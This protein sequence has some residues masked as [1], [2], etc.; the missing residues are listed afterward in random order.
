MTSI[1]TMMMQ[2]TV[3]NGNTATQSKHSGAKSDT[4]KGMIASQMTH[5]TASGTSNVSIDQLMT[6]LEDFKR[7]FNAEN[8][9]DLTLEEIVDHLQNELE[10]LGF[11]NFQSLLK[12]VDRTLPITVPSKSNMSGSGF[13]LQVQGGTNASAGKTDSAAQQSKI[14]HLVDLLKSSGTAESTLHEFVKF[15]SKTDTGKYLPQ[16][17]NLKHL[18]NQVQNQL[19]QT[20]SGDKRT[21]LSNQLGTLQN[22]HHALIHTYQSASQKANEQTNGNKPIKGL[23]IEAPQILGLSSSPNLMSKVEQYVLHAPQEQ[24]SPAR[25]LN[26]MAKMMNRG[27]LMSLPNG[28]TQLS[29]KLFPENL[30]ALDIQIVQRNGEIAAK[31]IASTAQAKELIE[32]NLNQLRHVLQG[33]NITVNQIEVSNHVPDWMNDEREK[34]NSENPFGRE[35]KNENEDEENGPQT[36]QQWMEEL[37]VEGEV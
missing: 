30:G 16:L 19:Q 20:Q 29:I 26:E 12:E 9:T 28:N 10:S 25:F 35:Q 36:F 24:E 13:L 15:M 5:G 37:E 21:S 22:K 3:M 17:T 27:R 18:L 4:F 32:T 34:Q 1:P 11:G 23:T 31:I 6:L 8:G 7:S 14:S 2:S 33:Q